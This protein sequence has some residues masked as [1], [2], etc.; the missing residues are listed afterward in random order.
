ML[1]IGYVTAYFFIVLIEEDCDHDVGLKINFGAEAKNF[2]SRIL[3]TRFYLW[4]GN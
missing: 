2:K 1:K 3:G 4:Y